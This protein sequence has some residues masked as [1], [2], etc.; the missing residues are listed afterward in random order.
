M[1]NDKVKEKGKQTNLKKYGVENVSQNEEIKKKKVKTSIKN[2]SVE[3]P[4]QSNIISEKMIN[5]NMKK[6]GVPYPMM[7]EKI[8]EKVYKTNVKN[9]RW[10]S[11]EE[12]SEFYKYSLSVCKYTL[13]NKKELLDK[14]NGC[15]YYTGENILENFNL[16]SN[17]KEYP[18]IDHKISIKYGFDN[19]ISIEKLSSLD[20]LCITTRSRN[21]SKGEKIETEFNI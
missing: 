4:Q 20:N 18:T 12:R 21:S 3:H 11:Y 19:N 6:L 1:Q 7:F 16:D 10:T 14:W 17:N 5:T 13:K 9:N 2:Y 15:D 8:K